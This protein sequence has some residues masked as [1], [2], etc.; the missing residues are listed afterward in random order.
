MRP[1][2]IVNFAMSADGKI[3]TFERRQVRISGSGDRERV[4]R[5]KAG[6]D[7]VMVGIGTVL[8]DDPSLT[9]KSAELIRQRIERG[10]DPHPVRVVVDSQARTPLNAEIL[11][12]G[13][14]RRVVAVS[15]EAPEERVDAI[16]RYATVFR[17]GASEVDLSLLMHDLHRMGVRR[18]MVEGGGTLIWSLFHRDLVDE[19]HCFVGN[20]IIG[21]RDAPTP[22]E[23]T[24]FSSESVFPRLNLES[25]QR[26]DEGALIHWRVARSDEEA[27]DA[28]HT[29]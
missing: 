17:A 2:V 24:G 12:K 3:S 28:P 22:A 4:D 25:L 20:I 11:R 7:A 5:M 6:S 14:G 13:E 10:Q 21:G 27:R 23:G 9:I 1:Y 18:L 29:P 26:L 15:C 16:R 8:A 19:M